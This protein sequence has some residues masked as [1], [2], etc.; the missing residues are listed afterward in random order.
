LLRDSVPIVL[1]AVVRVGNDGHVKS[2]AKCPA[3]TAADCLAI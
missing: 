2:R 1:V 3:L